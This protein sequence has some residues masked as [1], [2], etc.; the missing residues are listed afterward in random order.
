MPKKKVLFLCTGNSAHSQMAEG[1]LRHVAGERHEGFS[2]GTRPVGLN[3]HAVEAMAELGIDISS[4]RSKSVDEFVGKQF[5]CVITVCDSA[6]DAC[7]AF[8]GRRR[9]AAPQLPGPA[10]LPPEQQLAA[11]R[12]VRDEIAAWLA[13]FVRDGGP[14]VQAGA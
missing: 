3:P 2:A 7:P 12:G 14:S 8:P 5:D 6:N 11:F 9:V 1:L 13:H 4:H 10:A